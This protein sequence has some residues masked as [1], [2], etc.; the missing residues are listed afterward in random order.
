VL[1]AY[2][3][4]NAEEARPDVQQL[5]L[6][7][8]DCLLLCTDGM[9]DLVRDEE[10]AASLA[11]TPSG[12]KSGKETSEQVCQRLVQKALSTGGKDNVTVIV[13]RYGFPAP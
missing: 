4:D 13:A 1:T 3:G 8:G 11:E 12:A 10:I 2:L 6:D 5:R 9:T 7:D